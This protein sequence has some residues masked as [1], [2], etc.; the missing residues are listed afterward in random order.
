MAKFSPPYDQGSV[1]R[2]VPVSGPLFHRRDQ[3]SDQI[4]RSQVLQLPGADFQVISQTLEGGIT[5]LLTVE[6]CTSCSFVTDQLHLFLKYLYERRGWNAFFDLCNAFDIS[7]DVRVKIQ[8]TNS[9]MRLQCLD[10]L[11]RVYHRHNEQLTLVMIKTALSK[12]SDELRHVI[13]DY[14]A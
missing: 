13:S 1:K 7:D 12:H 4:K 9:S 2:S 6:R 8:D 5:E 11:H 14:N 10:V 3:T